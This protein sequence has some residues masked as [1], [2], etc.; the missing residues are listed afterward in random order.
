MVD[1]QFTTRRAAFSLQCVQTEKEGHFSDAEAATL[2]IEL[3]SWLIRENS[4]VCIEPLALDRRS[5][6]VVGT[7]S[8]QKLF[9]PTCVCKGT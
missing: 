3:S 8:K 6:Y 9:L 4:C 5:I 7:T 2:L 1:V